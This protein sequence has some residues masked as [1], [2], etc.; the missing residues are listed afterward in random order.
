MSQTWMSVCWTPAVMEEP[1]KTWLM[2]SSVPVLLSGLE[3]LVSLV[4]PL[5]IHFRTAHYLAPEKLFGKGLRGCLGNCLVSCSNLWFISSVVEISH[6][7]YVQTDQSHQ[8]KPN[9]FSGVFSLRGQ[10]FVLC[11]LP[12]GTPR[13]FFPNLPDKP[14]KIGCG[15]E[16]L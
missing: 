2:V 7:F 12:G 4:S 3:R 15:L 13:D 11:L 10:S 5:Q 1:V 16:A 9:L 8:R 14:S 6:Q